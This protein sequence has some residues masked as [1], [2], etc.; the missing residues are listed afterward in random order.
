MFHCL[1]CGSVFDEPVSFWEPRWG[2]MDGP[3]DEYHGCPECRG[4]YEEIFA[5]GECQHGE[6]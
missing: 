4:D 6:C 2:D 5:M 1:Q 3:L